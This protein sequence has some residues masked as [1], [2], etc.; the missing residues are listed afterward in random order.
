[1]AGTKTSK[2]PNEA[3]WQ[4]LLLGTEP[5][6]RKGRSMFKLI[7]QSPRCKLCLAPFHGIGKPIALLMKR[8]PSNKNPKFCN[9]CERFSKEYPGGAEIELTMLFADI[10][11]STT[12]AE[13]IS[14][15]EFSSLM[16]HFYKAANEALINS[17]ALV[18]KL[19]GDEVI[20]LF[21][22]GFVGDAH[23]Q[24]AVEAAKNILTAVKSMKKPLPVGIGVHTGTAYVGT[25]GSK[26]AFTDFTA[27]GDA[28]N[29]TARLSS[30]AK[31]G[32]VLISENTYNL[33][34]EIL[35]TLP[36]KSLQLKGRT[37]PIK[38]HVFKTN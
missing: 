5:A 6:L 24:K 37:K 15:S 3:L 31:A 2:N 27:L 8:A 32:E 11:G 38:V 30:K 19:V 10:R 23:P 25:V 18:D 9:S 35:G 4:S 14:A 21:I 34:G 33:S 28:V 36:K 7:P 17:D 16:N 12:L 26:E 20:G 13:K 22:P 29:I 1:M